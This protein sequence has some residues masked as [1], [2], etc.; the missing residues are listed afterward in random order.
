MNVR[1]RFRFGSRVVR[2]FVNGYFGAALW[3]E[4]LAFARVTDK[5]GSAA[6]RDT[7]RTPRTSS[8][9]PPNE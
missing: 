2:D 4:T 6:L 7:F 9:M 8:G 3:Q 1:L 5:T